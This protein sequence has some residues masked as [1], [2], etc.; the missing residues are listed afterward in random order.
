M[1]KEAKPVAKK[2][3]PD[4]NC[5]RHHPVRTAGD[6]RT[7]PLRKFVG[8]W[9]AY[10]M[11][12]KSWGSQGLE[13]SV[14]GLGAM[15]MSS[16]YGGRDDA[17]SAA[18]LHR[19]LDLG[20]SLIDTAEMYGPFVNERLI[21]ETIGSRSD[22]YALA[23]KTG[24]EISDDGERVGPNGSPAYL[25]KALERSLRNLGRETIDLYY[26]H[27]V[28]PSTPIEETIGTMGEF[29]EEG[30]VRYLGISEASPETIRRAHATYPLTA[31]QTE[32][33]LFERDPEVN[34]VL[35]TTRELGIEFVAYS[36]LG[37][38]VLTGAISTA[39]DLEEGD[40]RRVSPR[41]IGGNLDANLKVVEK[42]RAIAARKGITPGQLAL[43]WVLHQ[44][45]VVAIPG[46]KRRTYLEENVAA[47][48][49]VLTADDLSVLDEMFPV[50]VA[51]GER[52]P[53]YALKGLTI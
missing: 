8:I 32:Y 21:G 43:A 22:E 48:E 50:G 9:Q 4:H 27:R 6:G 53:D 40:F 3:L 31:V 28:D 14:E 36:P 26:I 30:K 18:T 7:E 41:F 13:A 42:L 10:L 23:T 49:V 1:A 44:E 19:A 47:A 39:A 20:V 17:E 2:S 12:T 45:G 33:S 5:R 46:T 25:R 34:G 16:A 51:A 15:G 24:F 37:R 52:Y 11:N 35:A 29:V 38:G